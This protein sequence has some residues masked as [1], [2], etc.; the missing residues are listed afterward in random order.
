MQKLSFIA[1]LR[2]LMLEYALKV[3]LLILKYSTLLHLHRVLHDRDSMKVDIDCKELF[4]IPYNIV[5]IGI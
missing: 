5:K 2:L 3:G 1:R 4:S